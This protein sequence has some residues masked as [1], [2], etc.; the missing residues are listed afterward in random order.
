MRTALNLPNNLTKELNIIIHQD[1]FDTSSC[2]YNTEFPDEKFM[3][4]SEIIYI[5]I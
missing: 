4:I 2:K 1:K 5:K 3:Y